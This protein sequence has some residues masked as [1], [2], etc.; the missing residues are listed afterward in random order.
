M[1]SVQLPKSA[2]AIKKPIKVFWSALGR[3]FYA[4]N[5][6]IENKN[7][8]IITGEKYDVTDQIAH[9]ITEYSITFTPVA[10]DEAQH[11]QA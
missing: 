4:S 3:R 10:D 9:A 6:Y 8:V 5:Q 7:G 2:K 1:T 11:A